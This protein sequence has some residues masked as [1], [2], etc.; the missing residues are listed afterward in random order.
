MTTEEL[1]SLVKRVLQSVPPPPSEPLEPI[2]WIDMSQWDIEPTPDRLWFIRGVIP[3]LQPALLSGEGAIGKSMLALH[4]M[5]STALGRDWLG[6]LPE[7]GGAWYIGAEDHETELHIRLAD[8]LKHYN[9]T[10]DELIKSGFRMKSLYDDDAVLGAPNRYG[11]IEATN[12]YKQI[13][14][15]AGDEKPMCIALDASADVFAGNE[16]DRVQTRQFCTLLRKL[17][18][19]CEGS[20]LL[21]AHPSLTGISTGTGLSGSTAWH[22]SVRAR[23]YLT[24]PKPEP[25]E[26][27]DSDLREMQFKKNQYGRTNDSLVLRYQNGLFLPEKTF[28]SIEMAAAEQNADQT[29]LTLLARFTKSGRNVG[30]KVKAANYAPRVFAKEPDAKALPKPE[31]YLVSAMDRLFRENKIHMEDYDRHGYTRI[32]AGPAP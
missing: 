9:T 12:L 26:Q 21:L 6:F 27:P 2:K 7:P 1:Q 23:L 24:S 5:A 29:F 19:V 28:S 22:N 31:K 15:Q 18:N 3:R 8:I 14:Q 16:I 11:I 20:V 30:D 10:Y 32:V 4:L 17:S 25:G 13:Y